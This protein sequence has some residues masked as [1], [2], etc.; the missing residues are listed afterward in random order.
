MS[1]EE[2]ERYKTL[3]SS[4]SSRKGGFKENAGRMLVKVDPRGTSKEFKYGVLDRDYN[5]SLNILER[6]LAGL[7]RPFEPVEI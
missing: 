1:K 7:R 6:G 4:F 2:K 5:A 3:I